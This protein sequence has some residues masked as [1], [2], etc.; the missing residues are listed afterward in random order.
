[1]SSSSEVHSETP[2]KATPIKAS[3]GVSLDMGGTLWSS[4]SIPHSPA[5]G[6]PYAHVGDAYDRRQDTADTWE[7]QDP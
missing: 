3:T 6:D 7:I 5:F 1:M 2:V 4:H